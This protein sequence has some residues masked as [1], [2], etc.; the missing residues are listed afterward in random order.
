MKWILIIAVL[1]DCVLAVLLPQS[2]YVNKITIT[3]SIYLI[4]L[5]VTQRENTIKDNI[6]TCAVYTFIYVMFLGGNFISQ[7]VF[8]VIVL[9]ISRIWGKNVLESVLE[10]SILTITVLFIKEIFTILYIFIL[11]KGKIY[12]K[13]LVIFK[14]TPTLLFSI[15][16][17]VVFILL[18]RTFLDNILIKKALVHQEEKIYQ[19]DYLK[20]R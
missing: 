1:I 18:Y 3:P 20:K 16:S 11:N 10:V 19:I 15:I 13:E 4:A 7:F 14:L 2:V 5:I 17:S 9:L 8:H 6:I 12:L